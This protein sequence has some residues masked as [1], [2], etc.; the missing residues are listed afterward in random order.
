MLASVLR[1]LSAVQAAENVEG[2]REDFQRHEDC[3]QVGACAHHHHAGSGQQQ[4]RVV[5]ADLTADEG[6]GC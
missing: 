2:Q 1:R 3:D 4:Q 6:N 5:L